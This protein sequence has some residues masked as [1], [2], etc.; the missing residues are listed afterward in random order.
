MYFVNSKVFGGSFFT[1]WKL[2]GPPGASV[3]TGFNIPLPFYTAPPDLVQ[4]NGTKVEAGDC[5]I[6]DAVYS[7]GK[8]Y[9]T[10]TRANAGSPTVELRQIDVVALTS[11]GTFLSSTDDFAYPAVDIDE[12]DQVTWAYCVTGPTTYLSVGY[13]ILTTVPFATVDFGIVGNGLANFSTGGSASRWGYYFGAELD[14]ADNRMVWIHG[15]YA[16]NAPANSWT[17]RVAAVMPFPTAVGDRPQRA[18]ML[19][20]PPAPNPATGIVRFGY[21][22]DEAGELD[23]AVYDARGARVADVA[24]SRHAGVGRDAVEFDARKLPSGV[25]F[26]KLTTKTK[27]T[28]RK[29]VVT[30]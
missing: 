8:L 16:S 19:L 5:R 28:S 10:Y 6:L 27:S 18:P 17:T 24:R 2:T 23:I 29:F 25:Y 11:S 7:S 4:P 30:H 26:V 3:L 20:D 22:I 14:P 21:S 15:T 1:L 13:R 9:P 12:N